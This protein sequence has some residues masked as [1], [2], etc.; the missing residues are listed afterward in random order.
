MIDA[1]RIEQAMDRLSLE[2]VAFGERGRKLLPLYEAL[3]TAAVKARED[4]D[5]LARIRDRAKTV[6]RT[7]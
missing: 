5:A 1:V 2:I 6:K 3:E 4:D 7:P